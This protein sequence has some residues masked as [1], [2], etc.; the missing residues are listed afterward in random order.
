MGIYDQVTGAFWVIAA[1]KLRSGL[2]AFGVVIG[3]MSVVAMMSIGEGVKE[4]MKET[5]SGNADKVN[6]TYS[7]DGSASQNS[8]MYGNGGMSSSE[9][10]AQRK[11]KNVVKESTV[12]LIKKLVKNVKAVIPTI[13]VPTNGSSLFK[14][15]EV[16]PQVVGINEAYIPGQKRKIV[17]GRN[18]TEQDILNSEKVVVVSRQ[19]IDPDFNYSDRSQNKPMKN[20]VGQKIFLAGKQFS[21]IGMIDEKTSWTSIDNSVFI[22][23]SAAK[24]VFG[25]TDLQQIDVQVNDIEKIKQTK[26]DIWYLLYQLS[27]ITDPSEIRFTVETNEDILKEAEKMLA[28][29]QMFLIGIGSISLFVWGIGIMTVMLMSV[30]ERTREIGIRKAIGASRPQIL[31]QFLVEWAIMSLLGG[32]FG[33]LGSYW[34]VALITHLTTEVP[35]VMNENTL[36]AACVVSIST[37]VIFS[38]LPAW[39][40]ANL[41]PIDALRFE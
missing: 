26:K 14:G 31:F 12:P 8:M 1:N 21:I 5:W 16:Y 7:A 11:G 19:A 6:I 13:N 18:I 36:V 30:T 23:T 2:S 28:Q 3:I 20:V 32:V 37:W 40:A 27:G 24:K 15:K 22:P 4:Q 9:Q 41:K 35:M 39:K 33:I 29:M 10:K 38:I 17:V 25:A 34:V